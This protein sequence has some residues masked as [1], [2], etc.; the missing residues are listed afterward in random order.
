MWQA[1]LM[2]NLTF[3][4]KIIEFLA[5]PAALAISVFLVRDRIKGLLPLIS[6][7]KAGP[8]ELELSQMKK[9]IEVVEEKADAALNVLEEKETPAQQ[10]PDSSS[11]T[12]P[13][14]PEAGEDQWEF[15]V[16]DRAP[17][18]KVDDNPVSRLAIL[19]ALGESKFAMRSLSGIARDTGL[20]GSSVRQML[21]AFIDLGMVS[22][23]LN[24]KGVPRY[25]LTTTG[26]QF[27]LLN[28][29]HLPSPG[30][31]KIIPT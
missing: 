22:Q 14:S 21:H 12:Q 2:D 25:F 4:T 15:P 27:L 24:S 23:T 1:L 19:K 7:L 8:F 6:K 20:H 9:A 28:K 3:I 26:S 29:A 17:G 16:E 30:P 18:T 5:W 11:Q 31:S 10:V 13:G